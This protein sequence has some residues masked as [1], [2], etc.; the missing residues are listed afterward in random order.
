MMLNCAGLQANQKAF[1]WLA[2]GAP[3]AAFQGP[4]RSQKMAGLL[5]PGAVALLGCAARW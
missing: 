4:N 2:V 1:A 3:D 5:S